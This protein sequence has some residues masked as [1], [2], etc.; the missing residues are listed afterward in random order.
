MSKGI[1]IKKIMLCI[2]VDY[3]RHLSYEFTHY[4]DPLKEL[5]YKLEM[6][7]M[8]SNCDSKFLYSIKSSKPDLII[9][10]PYFDRLRL[11]TINHVSHTLRVP[12]LAMFGDD[13]KYFYN[14]S[15]STSKVAPAFTYCSTTFKD[16]I[17]DYEHLGIKPIYAGYGANSAIFCK[18][19]KE[20]DISISFCG[21][22]R[23]KRIEI[24]NYLVQRG[25]KI[26]VYGD[27]WHE[28]NSRFVLNTQ[29]Y[30]ELINKTKINI[31]IQED[32][33]D[34]KSIMQIKGRDFE[35]PM[36]GGFLITQFNPLLIEFYKL[37][38]EIETYKSLEEL[39]KKIK[40]YLKNDKAREKVALAGYRRAQKYHK[41]TD[42]FKYILSNLK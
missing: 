35:V 4:I 42:R 8:E 20:K 25:H 18:A 30:I 34:N 21:A 37:G 33:I 13:E 38:K 1:K 2:V 36:C 24:L 40:F 27:D 16:A 12:T 10:K 14:G 32:I 31:G 11:E 19:K 17:P 41:Y 26:K 23:P 15:F 39:D 22:R 6:F 5:G 7:D 28:D 3:N 9:M 29:S